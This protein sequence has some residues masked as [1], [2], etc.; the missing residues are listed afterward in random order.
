[1]NRRVRL[2]RR[3]SQVCAHPPN[4]LRAARIAET[5]DGSSTLLRFASKRMKPRGGCDRSSV[6]VNRPSPL[7]SACESCPLILPAP[8]SSAATRDPSRLRSRRSNSADLIASNSA[9]VI[10][11]SWLASARAK[12]AAAPPSWA[13]A[14]LTHARTIIEVIAAFIQR[15]IVAKSLSTYHHRRCQ[16]ESSSARRREHPGDRRGPPYL[17]RP[18][19]AKSGSALFSS[20]GKPHPARRATFSLSGR[21]HAAGLIRD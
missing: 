18:F 19:P 16:I 7:V 21:Q 3:G 12:L 2:R 13:N 4:A 20:A 17:L 9:R 1:M 15:S 10:S 14:G 5:S 6:L 11:P 8:R